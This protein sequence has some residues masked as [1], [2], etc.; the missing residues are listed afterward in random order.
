MKI[1]FAY[2]NIELIKNGGCLP[3]PE[4]WDECHS[5]WPHC[6]G[7]ELSEESVEPS[8]Q[9][10]ILREDVSVPQAKEEIINFLKE[11]DGEIF[12]SEIVQELRLDLELV[13]EIIEQ[14]YDEGYIDR[15]D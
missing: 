6:S 1:L 2:R 5:I 7:W 11:N 14:L 9:I 13:I 8:Q 3:S 4:E 10:T 15:T 12:I